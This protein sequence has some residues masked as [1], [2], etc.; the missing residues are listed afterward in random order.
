MKIKTRLTLIYTFFTATMLL[1]FAAVIYVSAKENRERE[2]Y[3]SLKKEAITKANLFLNAEVETQTLQDIYRSNREVLNEVEVA[4]YDPNFSLL[5]HD[6]IDIDLVKETPEM[7]NEIYISGEKQFYQEKWQVIGLRY[8]FAGKDYIITATAV[9]QYGYNKLNSLLKT[10][11][12]VFIIS[13]LFIYAAGRYFSKRAFEPV[14]QMI[15]KAKMISASNLDLRLSTNGN[16]DE[17]S[18]LAKTF[19]EMLN[20]L[21]DSF[22]AHKRFVSNI[23]HEIRTPLAAII[24]ELELSINKNRNIEE[25]KV[26]LQNALSDSQKL[27]RLSNSL[28]DFAKASYDPSEISFKEVRID[29]NLLDAIQQVQ[30]SNPTYKVDIHFKNELENEL[31]ITIQGNE[32]LLKTAFINL[33]ENGCKFSENNTCSVTIAFENDKI[34]LRFSDDGIGISEDDLKNIF[35][36][37]YRGENQKFADGNG[38][39]LALAEKIILLH[40]GNISVASKPSK[41]TTFT[42]EL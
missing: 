32:Y 11:I 13:I 27:V 41:G 25:Y 35:T 1:V 30:K 10:I 5:Y 16:K 21:E 8:K 19:N 42:V 33:I 2:F 24:T 39:G 23:S 22:E 4:I 38:I 26:A 37:F 7:I 15:D 31:D 34:I 20:R 28:L 3:T 12:F 40:K 36:T 9:D 29:E 18:E 6:A 14:M 17:L